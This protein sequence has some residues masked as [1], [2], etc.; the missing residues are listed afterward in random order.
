MS[1]RLKSSHHRSRSHFTAQEFSHRS[2]RDVRGKRILHGQ[3]WLRYR[4]QGLTTCKPRP[5]LYRSPSGKRHR[6]V[7]I[8]HL[9]MICNDSPRSESNILVSL[10]RRYCRLMYSGEQKKLSLYFS[11]YLPLEAMTFKAILFVD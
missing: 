3:G 4:D 11:E 9:T 6:N 1:P 10:F 2:E 5:S 7:F 8:V